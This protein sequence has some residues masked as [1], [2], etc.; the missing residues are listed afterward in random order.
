MPEPQSTR[1]RTFR[2]AWS[3]GRPG[4]R[5]RR[6]RHQ[7]LRGDGDDHPGLAGRR[8]RRAGH[9]A[10]ARAGGR[11]GDLGPR[12][13]GQAVPLAGH[14]R[15]ARRCCS[16]GPAGWPRAPGGRRRSCSACS[17]VLGAR[18]G[19][20]RSAGPPRSTC[21]PWRSGFVTWLVCLSLLT[22]PLRR[23]RAAERRGGAGRRGDADRGAAGPTPGG[24]SCSGPGRG[25]GRGG[26]ARRASAGSS[27]AAGGTS[28]RPGGC[29]GCPA[30]RRRGAGT[31]RASAST[32]IAP[33]MT[34]TDDFYRIDTAFVVPAIEPADWQLR[35]HG[36]VD[37]EIVLTYQDLLA[38]QFTEALGHPQL[39]LQ[40]GRRRPDRQRLVERRAA[41]RPARAR[42]ASRPARTPCCRP[43]TTAGPAAPRWRR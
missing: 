6:P 41:R 40:P 13:P 12:P 39:R 15:A 34:P 20:R 23:R 25:R 35:I 14:P 4:R 37:R 36:M 27:A 38:R 30:S 19:R 33:W 43:P 21:C 29:S 3:V 2:G 11:D 28:R 7:L 42:P 24:R 9:P 10:D 18:R 31:A 16:P 5:L 17:P 8:R 22:E 26:G 1:V 32:G